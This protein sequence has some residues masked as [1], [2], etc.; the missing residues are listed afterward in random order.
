MSLTALQ[1]TNFNGFPKPGELIEITGAHGLEAADRAML[2]MLYQ[3]AHDSGNITDPNAEWEIPFSRLRPSSHE[4]NDR[5]REALTRLMSVQVSV[6]YIDRKTD[7]PRVLVTHL[8]EFFDISASDTFSRPTLRFG[9][10]R[11]L[12]PIIARSS[13]WGRIK[14]EVVCAMASRY[15]IA[16]YEMIQLRAGMDRCVETLPVEQFRER[17]GVK[18]GSYKLGADFV[19]NV[20]EPAVLEVNGLSDMGVAIEVQRRNTRA[21]I[22][23]ICISWWRKEGDEF[24]AAMHERNRPKVGRSARLRGKVETLE[25]VQPDFGDYLA[26]GSGR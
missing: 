24:R 22:E 12:R 3:H 17:M 21:P 20:I 9:L 8:F 7:E 23:G 1:K 6:P 2:N 26:T 11:Q 5:L 13:R 16:L 14:A 18:P 15:A 19:R 4:S 25:V 10:P